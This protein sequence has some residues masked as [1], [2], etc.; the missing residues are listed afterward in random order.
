[1]HLRT[2]YT[3]TATH[4]KVIETGIM[5]TELWGPTA[6]RGR[7]HKHKKCWLQN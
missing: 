7:R 4:P 6:N 2:K 5:M 1:M 3:F